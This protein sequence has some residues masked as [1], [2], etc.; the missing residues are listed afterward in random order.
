MTTF[1]AQALGTAAAAPTYNTCTAADKVAAVPGSKYLL[2]YKNGA[3]P[4]G[5]LKVTDQTTQIPAGSTAAAGFADLQVTT[6]LLATSETMQ[7]IDNSSRFIDGQGF[8]NLVNATPTTL[9]V[10]IV[11]P[12]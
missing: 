2:H 7:R 9:T 6:S 3:T 4:T 10:A 12:L 11:G 1:V 8:I 5:I